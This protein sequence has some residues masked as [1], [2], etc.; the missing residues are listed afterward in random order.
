MLYLC[1]SKKEFWV[2]III[3]TNWSIYIFAVF[4]DDFVQPSLQIFVTLSIRE[5]VHQYNTV[6]WIIKNATSILMTDW[7]TNIE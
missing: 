6:G 2:K 1:W 5:I 4:V 3:T 7:T